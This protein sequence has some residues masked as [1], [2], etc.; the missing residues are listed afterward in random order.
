MFKKIVILSYQ[1]YFKVVNNSNNHEIKEIVD[2][3]RF[4]NFSHQDTLLE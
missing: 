2:I 4:A 1:V 3:I